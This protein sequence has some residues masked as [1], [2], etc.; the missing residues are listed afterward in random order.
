M[1]QKFF[2]IVLIILSILGL[3]TSAYLVYDHYN[4]NLQG[5]I[6]DITAAI[7]CAVVNSGI[8]STILG[9]P[10]ALFGVLWFLILGLLSWNTLK[11]KKCSKYLLG[12]N[13]LGMLFVI[14]FIY[15]EIL[16]TT[17]CPFCTVVHVLAI[18]SLILSLLLYKKL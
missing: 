8:Y 4:P 18:F 16:L 10:V 9:I 15:I 1:Q 2:I 7:S 13:I 11:G 3:A 14:Y 12:W 5:S 17:I 6:C